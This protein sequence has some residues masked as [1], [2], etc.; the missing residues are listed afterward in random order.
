VNYVLTINQRT[1]LQLN[2]LLTIWPLAGQTLGAFIP[3][4]RLRLGIG[5]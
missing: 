3:K 5:G 4:A 1:S 2:E